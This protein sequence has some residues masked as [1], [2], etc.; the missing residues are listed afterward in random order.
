MIR[1]GYFSDTTLVSIS[2]TFVADLVRDLSADPEIDV[3]FFSGQSQGGINVNFSVKT[4]LTGFAKN[5]KR[6]SDRGYNI[7]HMLGAQ[8]GYRARMHI[9]KRIAYYCLSRQIKRL[10]DVAFVDFATSAVLVRDFLNDNRIPFI[11]HVHGYDITRTLND[12]EFVKEL[13][14]VLR[15]A[16]FIVAASF[17]MKRLLVLIGADASKIR[18]IRIGIDVNSIKPTSWP[19][20]LKTN[21]S[22][23]FL[24]RLTA[25]KHPIAL[26]HAFELVREAIPS[27][28]LTIIGDGPL[29]NEVRDRINLLNLQS[30]VQMLGAM[31]REKAFPILNLH[32]VYAQH[33]VTAT[34]GDQEGYALSVAEAAAHGIPIVATIHNGIPEHVID[35]ITGYL[36]PEFNYEAMAEKIA[37]LLWNPAIAAQMGEQ[38]RKNVERINNQ[39][40]RVRSIKQLLFDTC[41]SC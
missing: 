26:I 31:P 37:F 10:P 33:S 41:G 6:L 11:V 12:P 24:G 25:K 2:Q 34:S 32:W 20:R 38:G 4:Q 27:A 16:T 13:I 21:P 8:S 36:V 19:E 39:K 28:R 29:R 17:H 15:D 3:T 30:S 22:V 18:V 9:Q 23:I 1:L 5:G 40:T 35:G 7:A 14:Y